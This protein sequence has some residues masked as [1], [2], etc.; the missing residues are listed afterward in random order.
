MC[1]ERFGVEGG[2]SRER[3][4]TGN[5]G[6]ITQL[7]RKDCPVSKHNY[8][9][10]GSYVEVTFE[11]QGTTMSERTEEF[12]SL[13]RK[14]GE[15]VGLFSSIPDQIN[16]IFEKLDKEKENR[17]EQD[18]A[19]L[20]ELR[21]AAEEL[22]RILE[23][24][25][26]LETRTKEIRCDEH[27]K[28]IDKLKKDVS[29]TASVAKD[30]IRILEIKNGRSKWVDEIDKSIKGNY[31]DLS[32]KIGRLKTKVEELSKTRKD[33]KTIFKWIGEKVATIAITLLIA[34]LALKFGVK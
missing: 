28:A 17:T 6:V 2:I 15:L 7:W 9:I 26:E 18:Q 20:L 19:L 33:I 25:S 29:V 13:D 3:N 30:L 27:L 11:K 31:Q 10:F 14:I 16:L 23:R 34:W 12:N 5:L 4:A 24:V 8:F 21:S 22:K 1:V 32:Q